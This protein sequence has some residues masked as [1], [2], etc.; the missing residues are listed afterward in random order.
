MRRE[1]DGDLDRRAAPQA[2]GG[3]LLQVRQ[4]P[5]EVVPLRRVAVQGDLRRG[6]QRRRQDPV[7]H[8]PIYYVNSGVM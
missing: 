1:L 3:A 6:P 5:R 2:E 7:D 8:F 4:R